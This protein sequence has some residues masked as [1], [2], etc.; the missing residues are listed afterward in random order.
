[1]D[2]DREYE[3]EDAGIDAFDFSL[4]DDDERAVA[5]REAGLDPDDFDLI[6]LDTGYDAWS[7]LQ[8]NGLS[9]HELEFMDEEEKR[10]ALEDAGL[11]PDDYEDAPVSSPP[12]TF[13]PPSS[14]TPPQE[15]RQTAAPTPQA[16]PLSRPQI[17][18]FCGVR[19]P[20]SDESFFYLTGG[21][22]LSAGDLVIVPVGPHNQQLVAKVVSVGDYTVLDAPYPVSAAN[23]VLRRALKSESGPFLAEKAQLPARALEA[24]PPAAA[25]PPKEVPP[26]APVKTEMPPSQPPAPRPNKKKKRKK[27][28]AFLWIAAVVAVV[29]LSLAE[30]EAFMTTP[31]ESPSPP[32]IPTCPPVNRQHALTPAM[33]S[34]LV[35]TG[36]HGKEPNSSAEYA[37]LLMEQEKCR[38]CKYH[39]TNGPYSLCDYCTWMDRYGDGLP[40]EKAPDISLPVGP[41]FTPGPSPRPTP[42]P[43]PKPTAKPKSDDPYHAQ[44]YAHPEDFYDWY[45]DDFDDYE[46]AEDY[47]DM[48]N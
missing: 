26:P 38:N 24:E 12:S 19:F 22:A 44:D 46:D 4:M 42:R 43:T 34:Y 3:L 30:R 48:Y 27:G 5:L 7:A 8:D 47:W 17:Y 29:I 11:D 40:K 15:E 9:L 35:G 37:E 32:P 18:H 20:N 16:P 36:Y 31:P 39:T 14:F 41:V 1:M 28:K 25:E 33:A 23:S 13:T 6:E 10:K 45:Y 21:W 2:F